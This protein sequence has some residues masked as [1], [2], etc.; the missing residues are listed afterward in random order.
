GRALPK[1]SVRLVRSSREV[2]LYI[3]LELL[4]TPQRILSSVTASMS[5]VPVD[6]VS[7]QII[8]LFTAN[9]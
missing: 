6:W 9:K 4:G 5:D 2:V 7:W 8:E 1:N 3:P